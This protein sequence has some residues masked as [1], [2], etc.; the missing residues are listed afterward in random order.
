[1]RQYNTGATRDNVDGKLKY[2]GFLSPRVL[3]RFAEY[4]HK[5]RI[6]ADG[7]ERAADNWQKGMPV[8]DYQDS[9]IRH[10]MD[11]WYEYRRF[12]IV[13]EELLCAI[14]F[15]VQGLLHETIKIR[16]VRDANNKSVKAKV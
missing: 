16:E 12:G 5:H 2:E 6:Q 11:E 10:M 14:F 3:K 8:E 15:N 7:G 4:M 1:M 9:M 13:N